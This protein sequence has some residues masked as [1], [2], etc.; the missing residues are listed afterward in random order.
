MAREGSTYQTIDD[1]P[2]IRVVA[3]ICPLSANVIHNLVLALTRDAGVRDDDF[4]L[5]HL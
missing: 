3:C 5:G 1:V 2:S 4:E